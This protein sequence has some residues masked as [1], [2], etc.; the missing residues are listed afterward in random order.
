MDELFLPA[1]EAGTF[2]LGCFAIHANRERPDAIADV[3]L[4]IAWMVGVFSLLAVLNY[5]T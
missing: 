3:L 1:I 5:R 4:L 2:V